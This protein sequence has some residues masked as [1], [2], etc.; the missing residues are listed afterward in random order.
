MALKKTFIFLT[1]QSIHVIHECTTID[2]EMHPNP[3]QLSS[4]I[5]GTRTGFLLFYSTQHSRTLFLQEGTMCT[6]VVSSAHDH[7]C[8]ICRYIEFQTKFHN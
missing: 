7:G 5:A 4:I 3:V 6:I 8:D 2:F 1:P